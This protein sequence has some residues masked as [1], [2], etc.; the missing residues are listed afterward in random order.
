MH[1][2]LC[3]L[4]PTSFPSRSQARR[5]IRHGSVLVLRAD[6]DRPDEDD[7]HDGMCATILSRGRVVV[8]S[9]TLRPQDVVAIRSRVPDRFYPQSCT[10]YVVPPSSLPDFTSANNAVVF[11][12]DHIAIVIKPE[13]M[14]T[15]G[16]ERKDLQ[17]ILPFVIRPPASPSPLARARKKQSSTHYLPR[18]VHR[19]DRKTSGCVLVAKSKKAMQ[20]FS[21]LF[22]ARKIQKSYCAITFGEPTV[23]SSDYV[24]VDGTTFSV[25]DYPID[26]KEA[27]TLWRTV[28]T[29]ASPRW[30]TVSL[31]HLLPRTGRTHQIRRHLAYCL[32]C[33]IVGD[34][35]YDGGGV[36]RKAR[37]EVGMFLC[38]NSISF[39]HVM[40]GDAAAVVANIPLPDKF[41]KMLNL[42]EEDIPLCL[43]K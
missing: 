23:G 35:K 25:I 21:R 12:D 24:D 16:N 37:E 32:S 14:D 4:D 43:E 26:G 36:R 30:G 8:P 33:P 22:A 41:L 34:S 11:E 5:T 31:L 29:V 6:E 17:S 27:I 38:A 42:R 2:V 10:K 13:G 20:Q 1:R 28:A 19:L 39:G 3:D 40:L 7:S 18:P 9:T 15:I